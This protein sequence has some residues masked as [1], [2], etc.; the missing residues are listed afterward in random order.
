MIYPDFGDQISIKEAIK[1]CPA[2]IQEKVQIV[3]YHHIGEN[4]YRYT[5]QLVGDGN[6][7]SNDLLTNESKYESVAEK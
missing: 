1:I 7:R 6:Y 3:G 2:L 5:F 4:L